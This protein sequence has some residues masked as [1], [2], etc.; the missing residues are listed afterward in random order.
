MAD[1][2]DNSSRFDGPARKLPRVARTD[3]KFTG[4][5]AVSCASV[6]K[7]RPSGLLIRVSLIPANIA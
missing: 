1:L 3:A 5:L 2:R 7:P 4:C 6:L